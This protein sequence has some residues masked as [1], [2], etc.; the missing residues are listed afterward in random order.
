MRDSVAQSLI[1]RPE[2]DW[3]DLARRQV[4]LTER[5]L[6]FRNFN[7][8]GKGQLPL[9]P[10]E[11]WSIELVGNDPVR[12]TVQDHDLVMVD[13]SFASTLLSDSGSVAESEP[14]LEEGGGM[15]KEPFVLPLDPDL[16]LQRTGNAC[17][18]EAGF[19]PNSF[20]SE[21][22]W[23]FFDFTCEA[24]S[25]GPLGCHR[26]QLAELSCIE[27]LEK[28][29]GIFETT[30]DFE[31]LR[32]DQS[33][34]DE[35]RVGT[36]TH[37]DAP[38]L[39]V[40]EQDLGNSR[41][42]IRY[43][44]ADSCALLEQCVD[45]SG[46]RRLLQ[47]DA[48][49]HNVGGQPLHIG[50]VVAADP[51][52]NLFQY[53][54]CHDHFHF[55]DYGDFFFSDAEQN[56]S[57]K[58][59]FCVESTG[60]LSNN[61]WSPLTH[62]YHCRFQG[63]QAGW[64]DEYVAGLDCQWIDITDSALDNGQLAATIGF[65]SNPDRFLCEGTPVED[66]QGNRLWEPSGLMTPDGRPVQRPQCEFVPDWDSNN[67]GSLEIAIDPLGSYVTEPCQGSDNG[68]HI[69]PKRNCGFSLQVGIIEASD[70]DDTGTTDLNRPG[71]GYAC[72]VGQLVNLSCSLVSGSEPQAVRLCEYSDVL[73]TGVACTYQDALV[74]T[75]VTDQQSEVE[76]TCPLP[77][78]ER[79]SGG[80]FSLYTSSLLGSDNTQSVTCTIDG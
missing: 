73:D 4:K 35:V 31:R 78:D 80:Q 54:A 72:E 58:Q 36:V 32:W 47:F 20:D 42:A 40:V 62:N 48:T 41:V 79:E 14:A 15:W 74:N 44:P 53:N 16:L 13:Y 59:A 43:F 55:S 25:A 49:V 23:V 51:A 24:G 28:S 8:P 75:V 45:D 1:S 69:G 26:N 17:L 60:R 38:D 7:Y 67:L 33:M 52:Y 5:R 2:A 11:L 37:I 12:R 66:E 63:V 30:V 34:A 76:F 9:P 19:P 6:N 77:R 18:N 50:P 3:L 57:S 46:W 21:N 22:A 29:T 71:G 68:G 27:A 70:P 39:E 56:V 65:R 61:E 10:E 64:I